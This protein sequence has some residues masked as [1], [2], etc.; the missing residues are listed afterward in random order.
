MAISGVDADLHV[1]VGLGPIGL[2]VIDELLDRGAQVTPHRRPLPPPS[3]GTDNRKVVP[4]DAL[5]RGC[6]RRDR[7]LGSR[8]DA[9]ERTGG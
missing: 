3:S 1:V 8:S 2:A 7:Q 6:A 4:R 9:P 5:A